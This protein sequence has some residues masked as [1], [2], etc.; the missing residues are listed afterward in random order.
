MASPVTGATSADP[1]ELS[2]LAA[3]ANE[4]AA[5]GDAATKHA[6]KHYRAAGDALLEAKAACGHGK[7][8]KWLR[9]NVR[10]SQSMASR[11]MRVAARWAELEP[12]SNLAG[13]LRVLSEADDD[14]PEWPDAPEDEGR[15]GPGGAPSLRVIA[16]GADDDG[17]DAGADDCEEDDTGARYR[18]DDEP[19]PAGP[20][21]SH[22]EIGRLL[23]LLT[24]RHSTVT[25]YTPDAADDEAGAADTSL[26]VSPRARG[27]RPR[28]YHRDGL[29]ECLRAAAEMEVSRQCPRCRAFRRPADFP[30]DGGRPGGRF[31]WCRKCNRE[32]VGQHK[33]EAKAAAEARR[34]A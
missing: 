12:S 29:L 5:R 11:Y 20:S 32:N 7:W 2:E 25:V 26:T 30:R 23:A 15:A 16:D 22:A 31:S 8:L 19:A 10:F 33:A 28:T 9:A 18:D 27:E 21:T 13:A 6:L 14:A 34:Q 24:V 17:P 1:S 3:R 4:E